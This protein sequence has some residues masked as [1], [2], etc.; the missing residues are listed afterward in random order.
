MKNIRLLGIIAIIALIG[1]FAASC[2]NPTGDGGGGDPVA[3]TIAAIPGVTA[4]V[5]GATPATAI[6]PRLPPQPHTPRL[7]P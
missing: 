3:V 5:I 2:D 4:P 6:P 1:L 7:S